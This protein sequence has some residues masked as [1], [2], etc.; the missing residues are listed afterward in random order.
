MTP[1]GLELAALFPRIDRRHR[2]LVLDMARAL[3]DGL[4]RE[5]QID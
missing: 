5:V 3:V 1:E 4:E 2:K